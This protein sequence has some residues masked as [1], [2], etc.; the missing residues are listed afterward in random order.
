[1]VGDALSLIGG[2]EVGADDGVETEGYKS[3]Y[4]AMAVKLTPDYVESTGIA[5]VKAGRNEVFVFGGTEVGGADLRRVGLCQ[6]DLMEH[7]CKEVGAMRLGR[8]FFA[9]VPFS[10][11]S[12][13]CR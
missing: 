4:H 10:N 3:A 12:W 5:A 9:V 8:G 13:E 11:G 7:D 6:V 2:L 1:M